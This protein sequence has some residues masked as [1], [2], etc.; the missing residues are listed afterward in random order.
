MERPVATLAKPGVFKT[1]AKTPLDFDAR[2][3]VP[4]PLE[5]TA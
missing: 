2:P 5:L 4:P 3:T 1:G